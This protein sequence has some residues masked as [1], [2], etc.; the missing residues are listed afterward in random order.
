MAKDFDNI[1][2]VNPKI[3]Q[4][5]T[6]SHPSDYLVDKIETYFENVKVKN[7]KL[8]IYDKDFYNITT[9]NPQIVQKYTKN[10]PSDYLVE[11]NETEFENLK[12]LNSKLKTCGKGF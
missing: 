5:Y 9:V 8:Q 3:M 12:V 10:H 4:K 11:K 2:A 7:F 6:D 1:T